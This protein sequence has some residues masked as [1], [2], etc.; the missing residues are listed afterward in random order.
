MNISLGDDMV[1]SALGEGK[2]KLTCCNG[3]DKV[4][5]LHEVLYVPKL[6]KNLF[7]VPAL[8]QIGAEV[9]FNKDEY[10]ILKG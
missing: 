7:S 4:L 6:A 10:I 1:I 2:V 8:A 9:V 3:F 5:V